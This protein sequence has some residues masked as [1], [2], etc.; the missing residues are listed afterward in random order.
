MKK[1]NSI[2]NI[3][4]IVLIC[5]F[6]AIF[7]FSYKYQNQSLPKLVFENEPDFDILNKS[8]AYISGS[9]N[10]PGVY[11][12]NDETRIIDLI[13]TAGG[14]DINTNEEFVAEKMNLSKLVADQDHIFIPKKESESSSVLSS[15]SSQSGQED[16]LISINNAS[17]SELTTISG[18]GPATA[19]KIIDN[20]PYSKLEDLLKVQGIG[21]ATLNKLLPFIRL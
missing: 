4:L 1:L 5:I 12:V 7:V 16:G 15:E 6:L 10:N 8:Y 17:E 9:V 14:F 3:I 21:Q 13:N 2:Q 18:V 20:R 11:K 19:Q